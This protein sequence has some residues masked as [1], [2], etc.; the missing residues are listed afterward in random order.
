MKRIILLLSILLLGGAALSAQKRIV[1]RGAEPGEIYIAGGWYGVY[2]GW[3]YSELIDGVYRLTENGKKLDIQYAVDY[4]ADWEQI[5]HPVFIIAD[6]T[7][8]V[9]YNKV[10]YWKDHYQHTQL[11]V[12]FDYG[13]SWIFREEDRGERGYFGGSL[14][15]ILYRGGGGIFKSEDYAS[16][17]ELLLEQINPSNFCETYFRECEFLCLIGRGFYHTTDCF[18]NYTNITIGYEY[19]FGQMGGLFPDV[20]RGGLPGEVYVTSW[21]PDWSFKASFSADT[22]QS[23]RVVYH[24]DSLSQN[25]NYRFMSDRE[26]G[27]FYIINKEAVYE[28]WG[29]YARICIDYYRD[30]GETLAGVYC[31]DLTPDGV[32]T[33]IEETEGIDEITVYPNPTKN[34][35]RITNYELE[36]KNIM[37]FDIFGRQIFETNETAFDISHFPAGFYVMKIETEKGVIIKKIIKQ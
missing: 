5:A 27:V 6:A 29:W 19:V 4:F 25:K 26:A 31:H 7:P 18:Q 28:S 36:I 11:W 24:S 13:K 1:T 34:Q 32:V 20:F 16:N 2:A 23:F 17:W 9:L 3:G 33:S 10:D 8:G 14:E 22:G 21:F 35:L 30:Y 15:S 12:S 37:L